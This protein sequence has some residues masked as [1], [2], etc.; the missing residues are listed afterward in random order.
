ME[1]N[2]LVI[3]STALIPLVLGYVWYHPSL[4]GKAWM[5]TTGLTE[6]DLQKGNMIKLFSFALLLSLML[7]S[8]VP[9]LVI[10]QSSLNSLFFG[11]PGMDTN[12]ISNTDYNH[13]ASKYGTAFRTFKHG[14]FHGIIASLFFVLP[15]LGINALFERKSWKY[16]LIHLGYWM[17]TLALMGGI[18]C[19]FA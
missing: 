5:E 17:L 10:H 13:M 7:S 4:F 6:A 9:I 2:T 18:D 14:V 8:M 11:Q 19:A 15:V 12:P 16:I 1:T 3:I